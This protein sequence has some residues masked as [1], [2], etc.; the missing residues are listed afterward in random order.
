M[1]EPRKKG[2]PVKPTLTLVPTGP[3]WQG[4]F[5]MRLILRLSCGSAGLFP[6]C[7]R[8]PRPGELRLAQPPVHSRLLTAYSGRRR[9]QLVGRLGGLSNL[10]CRTGGRRSRLRT[11]GKSR[12]TTG[13]RCG[14]GRT[15]LPTECG[16]QG[17][18]PLRLVDCAA[19]GLSVGGK[20]VPLC[21]H[22]SAG[23]GQ[24]TGTPRKISWA[25]PQRPRTAKHADRNPERCGRL[26]PAWPCRWT[27]PVTQTT[28]A[29]LWG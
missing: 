12:L 9:C 18:H 14:Q 10:D 20:T 24:S 5:P 22:D 11:Y 29:G 15:R 23:G 6:N 3:P 21:H 17:S 4:R 2:G 13:R 25:G 1:A 28:L 16:W 7:Q 26:F 27:A 8:L 19:A